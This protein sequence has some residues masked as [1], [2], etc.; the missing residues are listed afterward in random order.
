MRERDDVDLVEALEALIAL[1]A[2]QHHREVAQ[3]KRALQTSRCIGMAVGVLMGVRR[4]AE[5]DAW[6]LLRKASRNG[7]RKVRDLAED[8][9]RLGDLP[10]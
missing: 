2:H 10:D 6:E 9:V 8:V 4:I 5:D 1:E 7:N 3:L